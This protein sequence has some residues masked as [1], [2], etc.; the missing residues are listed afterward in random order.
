MPYHQPDPKAFIILN[1]HAAKDRAGF[2]QQTIADCF[3]KQSYPF[4][5]VLT[6]RPGHA[7]QLAA[8]AVAAGERLIVA[9]GGDGT[10]N[11]VVDGVMRTSR[12]LNLPF[13]KVPVVGLIPIGRGNDFA[14]IIKTPKDIQEA[15][16]LIMDQMWMPTD[17]GEVVG[18]KFPQGRFFVNGVGIGFEPL[19]NFA[20]S[21]FKH[22][23]GMLSYLLGFVKVMAHYPRPIK[24][25]VE[26]DLG[27]FTCDTQ[28][29]SLCNGRRMGSVFLMGPEAIVDD[30]LLDVVYA[31]KEIKGWEILPFALKFFSG[32][33]IES[34]RFSSFRTVRVSVK[35]VGGLVCHADGE[36]ISRGCD[37]IAVELF[38]ASLKFIRK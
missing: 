27:S 8:Q 18:G 2:D 20:A 25:L 34:P 16:T 19:V 12:E 9:A 7:T 31:N 38:P 30:G 24:T 22:I 29:I 3:S 14:Y 15:C 35:A 10:V 4:E 11:E 33:Q 13:E 28:Q 26:S 32:R 1:P 6:E 36:E 17:C 5:I 37:S 21:D 23:S